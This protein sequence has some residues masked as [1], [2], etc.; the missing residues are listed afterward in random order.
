MMRYVITAYSN[1]LR[2]GWQSRQSIIMI[3]YS[4]KFQILWL[5]FHLHSWKWSSYLEID[6][7]YYVFQKGAKSYYRQIVENAKRSKTSNCIQEGRYSGGLVMVMATIISKY[8]KYCKIVIYY[9]NSMG[10]KLNR[11]SFLAWPRYC[12]LLTLLALLSFMQ[13]VI[14]HPK[15]HPSSI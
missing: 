1:R 10:N 8:C 3:P 2:I 7:V 4:L 13:N 5:R 9:F 14:R 15:R 6:G 12:L 11:E